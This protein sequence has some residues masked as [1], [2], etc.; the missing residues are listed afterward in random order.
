MLNIGTFA[1]ATRPRIYI[2]GPI[3]G[4][5]NGNKEAFSAMEDKLFAM[6]FDVENPRRS[7]WPAYLSLENPT[8]FKEGWALMMRE[9]MQQQSRCDALVLL[10]GWQKSKGACI[11]YQ[12]ALVCGQPC[13]SAD[14]QLITDGPEKLLETP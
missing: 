13:F 8:Q 6:G 3:S 1:F 12:I 4:K 7:A 14:L 10:P 11:E 9:A 2:S 5:P